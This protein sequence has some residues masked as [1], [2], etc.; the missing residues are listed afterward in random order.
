[1]K[2]KD[3]N[4]NLN[5]NR[6]KCSICNVYPDIEIERIKL[7]RS[8]EKDAKIKFNLPN[9]FLLSDIYIFTDK[10]SNDPILCNLKNENKE[11]KPL[12]D[13]LNKRTK[14]AILKIKKLEEKYKTQDISNV[15]KKKTKKKVIILEYKSFNFIIKKYQYYR[16]KNTI[17]DYSYQK[18][19]NYDTLLWILYYRYNMLHLYNNSQGAV[20]PKYY[21]LFS[22]KYKTN[23]EAFGS[24][25][26]H[27]LK[28]YFG[29]FPDL[30]KY[31][32]CLGNFYLSSFNN[33]VFIVNPPFTEIAIKK[34]IEF[35]IEQLQKSTS[36]LTFLFVIPSWINKDRK[37]LNKIC[38]DKLKLYDDDRIKIS[39]ALKS[40][41]I[42]Q[43]LLYCKEHF[44]YYDYIK[45]QDC[46]F[47]ATNLITFSNHNQKL[48]IE[49]IFGKEDIKLI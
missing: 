34:T 45:M 11:E 38:K 27:T 39:E 35:M 37:R 21:N 15:I 42:T 26:N 18:Y 4:I 41:F 12:Y 25:F 6:G 49:I 2:F 9:T 32:G 24:F 7:L 16:I 36:T 43:Y 44:T 14:N 29:L 10:K 22:K 3:N 8:I 13:Y 46:N 20:H 31:F 19:M 40:N 17:I 48:D 5:F 47:A 23:V 33:G 30:E 1:M 28:Y